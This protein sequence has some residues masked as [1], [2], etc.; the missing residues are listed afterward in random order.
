MTYIVQIGYVEIGEIGVINRNPKKRFTK[1]DNVYKLFIKKGFSKETSKSI[2]YW[3]EN[4][5]VGD[6]LF[7]YE[8]DK[9]YG[10]GYRIF[11]AK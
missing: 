3:C 1:P 8:W 6:V 5:P 2:K 9:N 7:E 10:Y 11:I 4:S